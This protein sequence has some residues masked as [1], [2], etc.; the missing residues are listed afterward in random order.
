MPATLSPRLGT[1]VRSLRRAEGL[2]QT[3]L[4]S[5][6]G[7][8]SSYLNLIEHDKRPLPSHLLLAVA[9]RFKVPLEEFAD[10][11]GARL[12]Q[13]L[14]EVLVDPVF[15]EHAVKLGEARE[16][17][18]RFPEVARGM[19]ALYRAWQAGQSG[20]PGEDPRLPSEEVTDL[21]Q[22]HLNHFPALEEAAEALR[23]ELPHGYLGDGL[24]RFLE[25]RLRVRVEVREVGADEGVVRRYDAHRRVLT[26]SEVLPP[27]SVSFQLAHQL[28]LL[29]ASEVIDDLLGDARLS[30]EGSRVLARVALASYFAGAVLM[31]YAEFHAAAQRERYDVELLGNRFRTSFEQV[32]HRL[33][34]LQRGDLPGVPFHMVRV[35]IAGNISKRFS[36][37]GIHFAR[38]SGACPR[39]NVHAAFLT[40][41]RIR[42]QL[43]ENEDGA[44]YFCFARTVTKGTGGWHGHH[45]V[46]AIGLG[47]RVEHA[48]RMVYADGFDLANVPAVP[49]G[50]TC[51]LCRRQ[52]C[53]QRAHPPVNA[54]LALDEN[55]RGRSFYDG[56]E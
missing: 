3:R 46:H 50:T 42:L 23:R 24:R 43:S 10:D 41:G 38:F 44:R 55:V 39:W 29:Y 12:G 8:S 45:S 56:S 34:T 31:P 47:C 33:T 15:G 6:L 5:E 21:L 32:C 37:S 2:S 48:Q 28:G 1:K 53:E 14:E 40:P 18:S 25:D 26:L 49:I 16:L 17:A 20:G 9:R 27:R 30:T 51:R 4:A 35:D 36:A 19:L 7:V 52:R 13:D 54:P 22:D 11:E